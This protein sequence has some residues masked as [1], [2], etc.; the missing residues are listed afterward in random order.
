[1]LA[2]SR[3]LQDN[4]IRVPQCFKVVQLIGYVRLAVY[5]LFPTLIIM[6]VVLTCNYFVMR[7]HHKEQVGHGA[8]DPASFACVRPCP[9]TRPH[10]SL[11]C[12]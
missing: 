10:L 3:C 5:V 8:H 11:P 9:R 6:V 4:L 2:T 12:F 1:M 7:H